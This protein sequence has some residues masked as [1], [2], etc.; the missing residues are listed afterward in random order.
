MG[1]PFDCQCPVFSLKG[2][3]GWTEGVFLAAQFA[4]GL[5]A[6]T[7]DRQVEFLRATDGSLFDLEGDPVQ[8]LRRD[9][10]QKNDLLAG[11]CRYSATSTRPA[12]GVKNV[13]DRL[14]C[15]LRGHKDGSQGS[16]IELS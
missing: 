16:D 5:P 1:D 12:P 10:G 8:G 6:V 2:G 3:T 13:V 11:R 9:E 4:G 7:G 15:G 14:I